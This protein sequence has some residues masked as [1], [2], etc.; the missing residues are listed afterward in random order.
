MKKTEYNT[1]GTV[2]K[3]NR[4]IWETD[5]KLIPWHTCTRSRTFL[6]SNRHFYKRCRD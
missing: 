6:A 2:S 4:T 3:S 5:A 1:V